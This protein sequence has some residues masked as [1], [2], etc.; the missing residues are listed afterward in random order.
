MSLG[1]E[2]S[3]TDESTTPTADA[4]AERDTGEKAIAGRSLRQIAWRRLQEGQGGDRRRHRRHLAV[5]IAILAPLL[6]K[7][8]GHPIDEYHSDKVDPTLE[9]PI[10]HLGGITQ[11]FLSASSRSTAGTCSAGSSTAR[12]PR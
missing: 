8:L 5:V 3:I 12:R 4:A 7:W 11:D 9:P 1:P 6:I 2:A 10:G